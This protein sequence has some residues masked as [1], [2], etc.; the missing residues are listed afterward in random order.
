MARW[1]LDSSSTAELN[2][3]QKANVALDDC[4]SP[5]DIAAFEECIADVPSAMAALLKDIDIIVNVVVY[6][7]KIIREGVKK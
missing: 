1:K 7:K 5:E 4:I 3:V 2:S 6:E